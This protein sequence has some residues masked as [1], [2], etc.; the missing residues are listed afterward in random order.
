MEIARD[1]TT[2]P[3]CGKVVTSREQVALEHNKVCKT[4]RNGKS[5]R[6]RFEALAK[7]E[8]PTGNYVIQRHVETAKRIQEKLRKKK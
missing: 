7:K 3:Y 2:P 1:R 6:S 4:A 8:R 5:V